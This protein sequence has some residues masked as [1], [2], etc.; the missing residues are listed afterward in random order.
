M[1][2]ILENYSNKQSKRKFISALQYLRSYVN[3]SVQLSEK[4]VRK[5]FRMLVD[6]LRTNLD[7]MEVMKFEDVNLTQFG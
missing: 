4:H 7:A 5:I 6:Q 3:K 2:T 1:V